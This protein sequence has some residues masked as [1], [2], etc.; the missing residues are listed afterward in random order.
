VWLHGLAT[1]LDVTDHHSMACAAP[2]TVCIAFDRN[3]TPS[4]RDLKRLTL[5]FCE[6]NGQKRVDPSQ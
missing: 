1:P 4:E 2:F 3:E 5:K 6:R